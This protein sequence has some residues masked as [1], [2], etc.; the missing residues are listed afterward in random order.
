M[1]RAEKK[2]LVAELNGIFSKTS[3][4]VVA[5]YSGLTVANMQALRKKMRAEG[6]SV[7]VA[8]KEMGT[9]TSLTTNEAGLYSANFLIPGQYRVE[10]KGL[11]TLDKRVTWTIAVGKARTQ[12]IDLAT[13]SGKQE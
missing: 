5:G 1:D 12:S 3:V 11:S 4:V 9:K 13:P 7:Q 8:N 10:Y 6:A 2:E